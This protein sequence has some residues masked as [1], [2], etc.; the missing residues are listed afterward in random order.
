MD[1]GKVV[2]DP[3]TLSSQIP[4]G[5]GS[6]RALRWRRSE[7]FM[8]WMPEGEIGDPGLGHENQVFD[9]WIFLETLHGDTN[10]VNRWD[11]KASPPP[12]RGMPRTRR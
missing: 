10:A 4:D 8:Q 5:L 3:V 12:C 7:A 9:F 11:W 1:S 6:N 2:I